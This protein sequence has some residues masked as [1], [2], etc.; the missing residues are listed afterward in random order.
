MTGVNIHIFQFTYERGTDHLIFHGSRIE[1]IHATRA[2]LHFDVQYYV[3]GI[4][5]WHPHK[6]RHQSLQELPLV[7]DENDLH[8][9]PTVYTV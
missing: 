5:I 3:K 2:L 6:Y 1:R 9:M 8:N 4:Q 7:F